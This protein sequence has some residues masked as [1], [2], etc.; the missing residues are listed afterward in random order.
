MEM[1]ATP[2]TRSTAT[3]VSRGLHSAQMA[4]LVCCAHAGRQ[5]VVRVF[6]YDGLCFVRVQRALLALLALA[7]A[8][9]VR[10]STEILQ[11]FS[12]RL[13]F[14]GRLALGGARA[15]RSSRSTAACVPLNVSTHFVCEPHTPTHLNHATCYLLPAPVIKFARTHRAVE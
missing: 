3:P 6:Y 8:G 15:L 11:K 10:A 2:T 1:N 13:V 14:C 9:R 7:A 5:D 4:P 12:L